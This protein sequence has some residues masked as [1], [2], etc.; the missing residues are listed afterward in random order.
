[1]KYLVS[2]LLP[3]LFLGCT[4]QEPAPVNV[5]T[6]NIRYDYVGDSLNAWP[7][8]QEMVVKAIRENDFDLFGMQEVLH[9]QLEYLESNLDGFGR[10]GI[11]RLGRT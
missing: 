9:R 6:F 10:V 8:R 2:P 5:A 1:M 7:N 4:Q 11:G 3:L